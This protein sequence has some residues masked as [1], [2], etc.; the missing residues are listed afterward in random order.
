MPDKEYKPP[1]EAADSTIPSS[2]NANF[3]FFDEEFDSSDWTCRHCYSEEEFNRR[4]IRAP[5]HLRPKI[6]K[7]FESKYG[8]ENCINW[9]T[10]LTTATH[11]EPDFVVK[12]YF[13]D[14]GATIWILD[15]AMKNGTYNDLREDVEYEGITPNTYHF[16]H[17]CPKISDSVHS[18]DLINAVFDYLRVGY[19]DLGIFDHVMENY[20]I[21]DEVNELCKRF[22]EDAYTFIGYYFEYCKRIEEHADNQL[23]ELRSELK[24][25]AKSDISETM[26][27]L[28]KIEQESV[29]L[30]ESARQA[31]SCFIEKFPLSQ[32]QGRRNLLKQFG[33]HGAVIAEKFQISDPYGTCLAYT[34]LADKVLL[35][36]K[37]DDLL[38]IA[39]VSSAVLFNAVSKLP[40]FNKVDFG[41]KST[42]KVPE[43]YLRFPV[44]SHG[45][46]E[47]APPCHLNYQQLIYNFCGSLLPREICEYEFDYGRLLK[48]GIPESLIQEIIS[49][50]SVLLNPEGKPPKQEYA[51]GGGATTDGIAWWTPDNKTFAKRTA[52]EYNEEE[53]DDEEDEEDDEDFP[54]RKELKREIKKLRKQ[55]HNYESRV[56]FA[57]KE[58]AEYI[59]KT[60]GELSELYS[61]REAI[62]YIHNSGVEPEEA[63][64]EIS[65]PYEAKSRI[66]VFG[67]HETWLKSMRPLLPNIRFISKKIQPNPDIIKNSDAVWIQT[68]SVSHPIFYKIIDTAKL[69]NIPCR[70]FFFGSAQ[71]CAEQ[72]A[73]EDMKWETTSS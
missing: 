72:L 16:R 48:Q 20:I 9:F 1:Y 32:N 68:N 30:S 31:Q 71:K 27:L 25:T 59:K 65:F 34:I 29:R 10:A 49:I 38:F 18:Q 13:G 15:Y 5:K 51:Y 33:P 56:Q 67:G 19:D 64:I 55:L 22:I 70:Y 66:C 63:P 35:P 4:K 46:D 6:L 43:Y 23:E 3:S 47:N 17:G 28:D 21:G 26:K 62:Y 7:R 52:Y 42:K 39:P 44:T 11:P 54:E 58:L 37:D 50:S 40:W 53:D 41:V 8:K 2:D 14:M 36:D 24:S 12:E 73:I 57:Q 45:A 60:E 69:Y 61:L